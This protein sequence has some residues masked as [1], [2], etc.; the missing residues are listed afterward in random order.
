MN[1]LRVGQPRVMGG[2]TLI[3][4]LLAQLTHL[5]DPDFLL[6]NGTLDPF[7]VVIVEPSGVH[8]IG[9]DADALSIEM[10]LESI[11]DLDAAIQLAQ[12]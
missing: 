10:L 1:E 4:L 5:R 9:V 6:L 12:A 11:P 3:P 7:A 2:I 8:A